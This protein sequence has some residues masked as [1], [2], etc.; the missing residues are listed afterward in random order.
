MRAL[1]IG[2]LCAGIAGCRCGGGS[3][4]DG[5]VDVDAG[6]DAGSGSDGGSDAGSCL[7]PD[8]SYFDAGGLVLLAPYCEAVA[9]G[10]Q[11][12]NRASQTQCGEA[13]TEEDL[14]HLSPL[15]APSCAHG[16]LSI[17]VR[18]LE[19]SV[20]G[21]RIGLDST[22]LSACLA[23]DGGGPGFDDAGVIEPCASVLAARVPPGGACSLPDEC[24]NAGYCRPAG[25]QS[26]GGTCA[27]PLAGGAACDALTDVCSDGTCIGGVCRTTPTAGQPCASVGPSCATGLGCINGSCLASPGEGSACS[28]PGQSS[29][30]A[31]GLWCV[32][33][34][35]AGA[36]SC[37]KPA[38]SGGSCGRGDDGKPPCA[39]RCLRCAADAGVCLA[40]GTQGAACGS[41]VDCL[42]SLRCLAGAC[43]FRPRGGE[44]CT[45]SGGGSNQGDCLWGDQTCARA[46]GGT[47]GRCVPSAR[48]G[49]GCGPDPALPSGCAEGYCQRPLSSTRGSCVAIPGNGEP[50]SSASGCTDGLYCAALAQA[51]SAAYCQPLKLVGEPCESDGQCAEDHCDPDTRHCQLECNE[52][53][54][55]GCVN[56]WRDLSFYL[57]FASALL[58][59]RRRTGCSEGGDERKESLERHEAG[60]RHRET[61]ASGGPGVSGGRLRGGAAR[62]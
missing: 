34:R 50:C 60:D 53:P 24:T 6:A 51:C 29:G 11:L 15:P 4:L 56:G 12:S 22:K 57:F 2:L 25:P 62:R 61:R 33:L 28:S 9:R 3:E 14:L 20:N 30:C 44:P 55:G 36:G 8:A 21:G 52:L 23:F 27:A 39:S 58:G 42:P 49:E 26:C 48:L 37:Q 41:T 38:Q 35:D 31:D 40:F 46:D 54:R 47:A 5:G 1:W 7:A 19:G 59:T 17:A 13:L 16:W 10:L 18:K 45:A 32:G 43:E